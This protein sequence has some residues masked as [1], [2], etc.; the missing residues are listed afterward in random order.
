MLDLREPEYYDAEE[1]AAVREIRRE[2]AEEAGD[3]SELDAQIAADD[4]RA[5]RNAQDGAS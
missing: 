4:A 2:M 5:E 1:A 3:D